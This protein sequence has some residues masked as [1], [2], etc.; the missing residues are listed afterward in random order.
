MTAADAGYVLFAGAALHTK[1]DLA[2][3]TFEI[4]VVP[5]VFC[6]FDELADSGFPSGCQFNILPV[7]GHTPIVIAGEHPEQ[8]NDIEDQANQ[9][10][11]AD[12]YKAAH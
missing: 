7:F 2:I 8:S 1:Q 11:K 12:T 4:P 10:K 9:R 3:R 6:A 5:A